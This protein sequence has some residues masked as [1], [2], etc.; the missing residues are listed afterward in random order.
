MDTVFVLLAETKSVEELL[1]IASALDSVLPAVAPAGTRKL[2]LKVALLPTAMA[3]VVVQMTGVPAT[4]FV[5]GWNVV[6]EGTG[7]ATATV[8]ATDGPTLVASTAITST[9][10]AATAAGAA[11]PASEMSLSRV[12]VLVSVFVSLPAVPSVTPFATDVAELRSVP[13]VAAAGTEKPIVKVLVPSAATVP[14][15]HV[16]GP[17]PVQVTDDEV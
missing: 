17:V 15:A 14:T 3:L 8:S 7:T 13:G 6:P 12:I 11:E 9:A 4:Q 1:E 10:P 5:D 2:T 16:K